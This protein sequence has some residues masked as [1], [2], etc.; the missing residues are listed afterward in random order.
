MAVRSDDVVLVVAR[1][2][3]EHVVRLR[4]VGSRFDD[5]FELA[6]GFLLFAERR[7]ERPD[8]EARPLIV[9]IPTQVILR[10]LDGGAITSTSH[11]DVQ[12]ERKDL[13]RIRALVE[14]GGEVLLGARQ[15]ADRREGLAS[16]GEVF[17]RV[18]GPQALEILL[19]L[20]C[21]RVRAALQRKTNG[22]RTDR[23]RQVFRSVPT[24]SFS[25]VLRPRSVPSFTSCPTPS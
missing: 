6:L 13:F 12:E 2:D 20:L 11:A 4:V 8:D 14:R 25:F 7:V 18:L 3:G 21:G 9:R 23:E 15:I 24:F 5:L 22:K 10:M 17:L 19:G 1:E 16:L